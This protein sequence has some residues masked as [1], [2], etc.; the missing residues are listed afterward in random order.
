MI[1]R[2]LY[3][4]KLY[5]TAEHRGTDYSLGRLG[6]G[7]FVATRRQSLGRRHIGGGKHYATLAEVAAGCRAFGTE[8]QLVA[9]VY[10][11]EL[12]AA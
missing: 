3:D 9:A 12:A 5:L 11:L 10:G 8:Q 6:D 2:E 4:G 1:R 7:W